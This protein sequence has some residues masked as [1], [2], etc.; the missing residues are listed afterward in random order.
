[1]FAI[2]LTFGAL[3]LLSCIYAWLHGGWEGRWLAVMLI[4]AALLSPFAQSRHS[5]NWIEPQYG[6]L[7][8]D[9]VLF[10]GMMIVGYFSDRYWPL[11]MLAFHLLSVLT[12]IV[13]IIDQ[14][15]LARAY[16]SAASFWSIP[17][18]LVM[19]LGVMLDRWT[20]RSPGEYDGRGYR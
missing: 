19:A 7:I 11:W 3:W 10:I 17:I 4:I 6:V 20:E 9:L 15:V 18:Q 5:Q 16:Q 13:V 14:E 12:H 2:Y 8:V 1:M